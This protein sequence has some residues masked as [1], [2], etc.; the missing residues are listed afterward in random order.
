[1]SSLPI[2]IVA[3]RYR[4]VCPLGSG[5]MSTVYKAE[6]IRRGNRVVAVK[7]LNVVH[8]DETKREIF[9]RETRALEQLEH[10]HIIKIF[11]YGWS[12]EGKCHYIVLEYIPRTLL[13]VI[14]D[15]AREKEDRTWCW[16]LMREMVD[17]LVHA[18]SQGV[19][20]RD[21]KPTN[22][23]ITE[24]GSS[25]LTDFGISFLKFELG[26]GVTVSQFW[27]IGYAAPEQ[28]NGQQ[29]TEQSDIYSLG[30]VF[31]HLLSGKAPPSEGITQDHLRALGLPP[32]VERTLQQMVARDPSERFENA[33]QLQRRLASTQRYEPL[34][35]IYF[36]V[37]DSARR[38]LFDLGLLKR[39]SYE[40]ACA[41]L[42]AEL[43]GDEPKEV[44][45]FL[46]KNGE[47]SDPRVLTDTLRL[48]C[49]RHEHL[50]LL[51]ITTIHA[52]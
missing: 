36:L 28:R 10:P 51:V 26:T 22:I 2:E 44:S 13:D 20:H 32:Q 5:T 49:T 43:G 52:P 33:L 30:C 41:Y 47:N 39:S 9:R 8:D 38:E 50:P 7:L 4:L 46:E 11:D 45:L 18:H 3:N 23:L 1:M 42:T 34:L 40:A 29:A 15:H 14:Q 37:T 24:T 17:T 12:A 35:E 19:I 21:L 16:P 48:I 27:S 25:K 31:Y 6:D